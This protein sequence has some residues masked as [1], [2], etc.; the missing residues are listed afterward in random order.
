MSQIIYLF[1]LVMSVGILLKCANVPDRKVVVSHN[2][3][4]WLKNTC[5]YVL[6]ESGSSQ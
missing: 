6:V 2:H 5:F 3:S 4:P 1:I